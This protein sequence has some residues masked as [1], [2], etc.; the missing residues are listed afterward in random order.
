MVGNDLEPDANFFVNS[1]GENLGDIRRSKQSLL[2]KLEE[3]VGVNAPTINTFRRASE[4]IVQ[5]NS[6]LVALVDDLQGHSKHVGATYYDRFRDSRRANY[7]SQLAKIENDDKDI[8]VSEEI[9]QR[10]KNRE[11][12]ELKEVVKI[13]K[14]KL[15][16]DKIKKSG[17][18]MTSFKI[19]PNDRDFMQRLFSE[20]DSIGKEAFPN[21][22]DWVKIF[23]RHVDTRE[24]E[25]GDA[26]R[27]IEEN[28]FIEFGK[29][30]VKK[31]FGPWTGSKSQN[32]HADLIIA[33]YIKTCFRKAI[34]MTP[35][36]GPI[37]EHFEKNLGLIRPF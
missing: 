10:R 11:E 1:K 24:D 29:E 17:A 4:K 26:L 36:L 9:K 13:A 37:W 18:K 7:I 8:E 31:K 16:V 22:D 30:E 19:K 2:S 12:K 34:K 33:S 20:T 15:E 14:E 35:S 32:K 27:A 21:D 23:Y 3:T 5:E 6:N 25:K 28:V